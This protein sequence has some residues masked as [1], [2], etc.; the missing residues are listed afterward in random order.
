MEP[1]GSLPHSQVP[2]TCHWASSIQSIPPHP[3]YWRSILILSSHLRLCL[4]SGLFLSG[5]PTKTLYTSLFSPHTRY[6]PRPSNSRFY[7]PNNIGWGVQIIKLPV[8][9][10][11]NYSSQHHILKHPQFYKYTLYL[12]ALYDSRYTQII[13]PDR[14]NWLVYDIFVNCNWV[15]T[16]WQ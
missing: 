3:T 10:R 2:A 13:F 8:P 16:R 11:P 6:M 15:A 1:E 4:P 14:L 12:N 9:L 5:F 7:H